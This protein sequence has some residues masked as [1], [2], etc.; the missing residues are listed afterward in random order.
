VQTRYAPH[1]NKVPLIRQALALGFDHVAWLDADTLIVRHE[2]DLRTALVENAPIGMC[3]H[4]SEG[5]NGQPHHHNSGVIIMRNTPLTRQFFDE[6]WSS[7]PFPHH[8]QDQGRIMATR[9]KFPGSVQTLPDEWNSTRGVNEAS[10]PIIKAWHGA[11]MSTA[12]ML[13]QELK[14]LGQVTAA[15]RELATDFLHSDNF[16]EEMARAIERLPTTTPKFHGR[17][18]VICAGSRKYF[19]SAWVCV[20]Q[21]RRLGCTLPIQLWY[22][23]PAEMDERM[24]SLVAPF[25]VTCVDG[26]E[27]R[28]QF[29]ARILNGWE[30]KPYAI[31]HSPFKEVLLLD[32]DNF[33]LANPEF[34][35][36]T[37]QFQETGAIFWPDY[38][39]M[40]HTREAWEIFGV[41]YRHEAEFESGQI[42]V[43]KERCW[44]PLALAMW[45][46]ENSDFFYWY[47][48]GDKDT[49]RMAWHR[50]G[51]RYAMPP[52]PVEWLK[53][54]MCQHDFSGRRI[55]QH[56]NMAK[57]KLDGEN[58]R[59]EGFLFEDECF[60]DL[61]RL[62]ELWDGHVQEGK[63]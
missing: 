49:Y 42:V 1:W 63:S 32:A 43:D 10:D 31:I 55:F 13:Y 29:P 35:F 23:G 15:V 11:R 4:K 8:W 48:H 24:K 58:Q 17:G 27:V 33:P 25:D 9:D 28:K 61:E 40:H 37:P 38:T 50:L 26:L 62:R 41:P 34:L 59:I 57:W 14:R 22:L 19:T 45:F 54:T 44:R 3:L 60:R 53:G 52:F 12:P 5:W 36:E 18:I 56:R 47:V 2:C 51:Q 16:A 30:L 21:L 20:N 46:N 39:P 6:V 7:G